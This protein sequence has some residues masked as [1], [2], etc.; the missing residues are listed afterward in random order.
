MGGKTLLRGHGERSYIV[1][2]INRFYVAAVTGSEPHGLEVVDRALHVLLG[3]LLLCVSGGLV[4][5]LRDGVAGG[6]KA[7]AN[8]LVAVL[9]SALARL[10]LGTSG[11]SRERLGD[12][13]ARA[14]DGLLDGLHCCC[15]LVSH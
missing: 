11:G 8:P 7:S 14:I 4:T 9:G 5:L 12:G 15:L 3:V 10:L 6:G 2:G 1:G 13:G